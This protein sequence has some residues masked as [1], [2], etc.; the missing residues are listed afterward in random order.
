MAPSIF[1]SPLVLTFA[2]RWRDVTETVTSH[3]HCVE[4][5][6]TRKD[7]LCRPLAIQRHVVAVLDRVRLLRDWC[8]SHVHVDVGLWGQRIRVRLVRRI[9]GFGLTRKLLCR[10]TAPRHQLL[11]RSPRC[12]P[13][14]VRPHRP[15]RSCSLRV[16]RDGIGGLASG[17]VPAAGR[18]DSFRDERKVTCAHK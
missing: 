9:A 5:T 10:C 17:R 15:A 13:Y 11:A 12:R 16:L 18:P 14:L 8:V 2:F 6:G 3:T 1:R 7:I 4:H